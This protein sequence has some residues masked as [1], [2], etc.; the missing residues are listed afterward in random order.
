MCGIFGAV[1]PVEPFGRKDH[2]RF[3]ELTDI[4]RYRGPDAVGWHAASLRDA[5]VNNRE[6]FDVF[7]GHRRLS[8]IDL[9]E[10][11]NQPMRDG[12]DLVISFNGEIFNY[13]E[14]RAELKALGHTFRTASDTEVILKI[15]REFGQGGFARLNGMWAFAILDRSRFRVILSRDRFSIKPLYYT[16]NQRGFFFASEIKQL[17]PLLDT[18]NVNQHALATYLRQGLVDHNDET[19]FNGIYSVKPRHNLTLDV[20]SGALSQAPYWDYS[21]DAD[22]LRSPAQ[23]IDQF[24]ALFE[25]SVRIRLRSDV[26]VAALLSGGL[27]SS[28]IVAVG[29]RGNG[30]MTTFSAVCRNTRFSED[31]HIDVVC[32]ATGSRNTKVLIDASKIVDR[33]A[34]TIHHNDE[35]LTDFCPVAHDLVL[36]A[37]RQESDTIVLLSGQ[38]GD[39]ILMGYLKYFFFYL[40]HLIRSGRPLTAAIEA[41]QSLLKGTAVTQFA[42][43]EARRYLGFVPAR[44]PPFMR[45]DCVLEPIWSAQ[46]LRMRQIMDVE[47]YSIPALTHYEDRTSMAHSLEIRMPFL[48]HR[49]VNFAINLPV[50]HKLRNGWGKYVL[51]QAMSDL[52]DPIRWRRDKQWFSVP[53]R[54][55]LAHDFRPCIE[56]CFRSSILDEMGVVDSRAYLDCYAAFRTAARPGAHGSLARVFL[57]ELWAKAHFGES[58]RDAPAAVA[59]SS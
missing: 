10:R 6:R 21:A 32:D 59:Y 17:L 35:P 8:I 1:A 27:D 48:D 41:G 47:R 25:D 26:N 9:D 7:L 51:R 14:L 52:P 38:G 55:W 24:R 13:V 23:V 4:V 58:M 44:K 49:L 37:S 56:A 31:R 45:Q 33:L 19:F 3:V 34:R 39:E 54:E 12:S 11:S 28:S 50:E 36:E 5:R 42:A 22:A 20:D 43:G 40:A 29:S 2:N 46:D 53:D 57:G 30:G 16:Q 15:Y 18:R